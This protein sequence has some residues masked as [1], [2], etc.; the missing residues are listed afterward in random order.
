MGQNQRDRARGRFAEL[1]R[2]EDTLVSTILTAEQ[3][4]RLRQI[5]LQSQG[6]AAFRDPNVIAALKLTAEQSKRIRT[7]EAETFFFGPSQGK[8]HG[9]PKDDFRKGFEQKQQAARQRALAVLTEEQVR[10]WREMTGAPFR[11]KFGP[12]PGPPR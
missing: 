7:I 6:L 2:S 8:P 4:R 11:S 3:D 12:P 1:I 9:P 5:A 10:T